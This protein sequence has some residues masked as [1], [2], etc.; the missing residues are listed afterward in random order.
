MAVIM[1]TVESAR[2]SV[3][4]VYA[5]RAL[6]SAMDSILAEFYVPLLKEY[7]IF[8]LEGSYGNET[9]QLDSI[10]SKIE[11]TM[12]YS[13]KPN[14]DLYYIDNYI[15][16]E[17]VNLL[18]IQTSNVEISNINTML[19]YDGDLFASQAVSYM[20]YKELGN[21]LESFLIKISLIEETEQAQA[22]LNEK[23]KTEE[24]IYK[25]ICITYNF[26]QCWCL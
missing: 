6:A 3:G 22:V 4:K 19:D 13:F 8:G 9:L 26:C 20:K 7:H 12:E 18:D 5:N 23:F 10:E 15:P 16:V 2:I 1:T 14:K 21:V 24:S 17:N 11:D 25:I